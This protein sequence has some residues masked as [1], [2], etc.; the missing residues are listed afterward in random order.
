MDILVSFTFHLV[1]YKEENDPRGWGY[2]APF[3]TILSVKPRL[4]ESYKVKL[5]HKKSDRY[6]VGVCHSKKKSPKHKNF[7]SNAFAGN[8]TRG[9]SNLRYL[10]L[11]IT[12]G[13]DRFYH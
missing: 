13:K 8:R 10:E 9:Q 12:Y 11:K 2:S 7:K 6:Q 5:R 4:P 1:F 3:W